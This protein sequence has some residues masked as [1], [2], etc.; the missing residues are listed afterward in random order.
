MCAKER[1]LG[2]L[3]VELQEGGKRD[4]ELHLL[5][6]RSV[7]VASDGDNATELLRTLPPTGRNL[8]ILLIVSSHDFPAQ[9][10]KDGGRE[11]GLR[12]DR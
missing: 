8:L 2:V 5:L 6:G 1:T 4:L 11:Q 7:C 10:G 3:V 12:C 9:R